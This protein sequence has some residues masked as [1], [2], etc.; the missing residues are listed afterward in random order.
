VTAARLGRRAL[1]VVENSS[2]PFD[3]RV[4]REAMTL[5]AAGWLVSVISPMAV[6]YSEGGT[7]IRGESASYELLDGIHVYRYPLTAG[8][9]G[10]A[11]FAREYLLALAHTW[12]LTRVVARERS[13]DVMQVCNPPDFFFPFGWYCRWTGRAFVFDHHD[14]VPESVAERWHGLKGTVIGWVARMAERRMFRTAHVVMC[15]NES[16]RAV[17]L[18]RGG[19]AYDRTFVVRNGPIASQVR[20]QTPDASLRSGRRYLVGYLGIMGPQDGIPLLLE[21]V[22]ATV[23]ELGRRDVQFLVVGDGP[24]RPWMLAQVQRR[25]VGEFVTMPG[26]AVGMDDWLRYLSAPDLCLA[27]EP[28]TAFTSRSTITKVAEYMAMEQPV[29]AFDLHE[30]RF[31]LGDAG[32]CVAEVSGRALAQAIVALLDDPERRARLGAIGRRRVEEMFS[33]E[34]QEESLVAAYDAAFAER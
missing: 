9:G 10:L 22:I 1:I 30:T 3:R 17:A 29:V 27:P 2:V 12:R 13:F 16:Y 11:G 5:R 20:R 32:V 19:V 23:H 26:L 31:T 25:A 4:W 18:E 28:P 15:T 8:E 7:V 24:L 6:Q 34:R 21:A 33:W 14:L